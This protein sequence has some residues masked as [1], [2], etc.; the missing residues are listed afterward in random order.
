MRRDRPLRGDDVHCVGPVPRGRHVH[1]GRR[2]QQSDCGAWD[3]VQRAHG[4]LQRHLPDLGLSLS[5]AIAD[6][7]RSASGRVFGHQLLHAE[8]CDVR[9]NKHLSAAGHVH[10]VQRLVRGEFQARRHAVRR[11]QSDSE[12]PVPA[13]RGMPR[14]A[15]LRLHVRADRAGLQ[16]RT[17]AWACS[18]R[19]SASASRAPQRVTRVPGCAR[20]RCC[21]WARRAPAVQPTTTTRAR[22]MDPAK[23]R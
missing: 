5:A 1:A 6:I 3:A 22:A 2:V 12:Q 19:R 4:T 16:A 20:C 11:L 10:S 14:L 18:V 21:R 13:G 9:V 23:V 15:P 7:F 8:Q 17:C